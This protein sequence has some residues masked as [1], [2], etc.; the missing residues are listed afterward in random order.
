MKTSSRPLHLLQITDPHL[1]ANE[2]GELLGIRTRESLQ[3]VIEHAQANHPRPD[4]VLATGDISQDGSLSSYHF[5]TDRIATLGAP[6][7]WIPG[8]HDQRTAMHSVMAAN[9]ADAR[10][11][12]LGNWQLVMLDS[13]VEG[14]VPGRLADT[15]LQH[16]EDTLAAQ[17]ERPALVCVHHHPVDISAQWMNAIGLQNR[18]ALFAV[19]KR[20]PQVQALVFGHVHQEVDGEAQ[21]LRVLATPSTCVQFAPD[22]TGFTVDTRA[23]GYRWLRLYP[24]G[25]L[26]TGVER[27]AEGRFI[28]NPDSQGY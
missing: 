13:L 25:T 11:P 20:H 6:V 9:G 12:Q 19:L 26:E 5:F 2:H 7:Y 22:V 16:L 27:V 3:A 8:N 28:A 17:P 23:P 18:D 21:G 24:D 14:Q 15:E 10:S 1:Q 4:A